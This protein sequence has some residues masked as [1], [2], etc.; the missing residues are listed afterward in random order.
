MWCEQ[1]K[2][3]HALERESFCLICSKVAII[4]LFFRAKKDIN[5]LWRII[6]YSARRKKEKIF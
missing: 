1:S 6:H 5:K 3:F 2:N 4:S